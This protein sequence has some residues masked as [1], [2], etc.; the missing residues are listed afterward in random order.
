MVSKCYA[1]ELNPKYPHF[2]VIQVFVTAT[3]NWPV[4]RVCRS[5]PELQRLKEPHLWG[6]QRHSDN[7]WMLGHLMD[8]NV[9][10]DDDC[11]PPV[12]LPTSH[13]RWGH[14]WMRTFAPP[15]CR[16]L[17]CISWTTAPFPVVT[18]RSRCQ[19]GHLMSINC[20]SY[21]GPSLKVTKT[22]NACF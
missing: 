10:R 6:V 22:E 9:R 11:P 13:R 15:I 12:L 17:S 21:G 14:D 4:Q 8:L 2:T 16:S 19:D 7:R 18:V 3:E 20:F 5:Q 1:M